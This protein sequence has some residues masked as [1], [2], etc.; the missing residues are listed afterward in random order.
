MARRADTYEYTV[1]DPLRGLSPSE[2]K[3]RKE[4]VKK[5]QKDKW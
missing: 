5:G 3:K 2:I 4:Q 1:I